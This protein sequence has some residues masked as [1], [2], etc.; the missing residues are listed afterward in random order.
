MNESSAPDPREE[1]I[2]VL[3]GGKVGGFPRTILLNSPVTGMMDRCGARWPSAHYDSDEMATLAAEIHLAT[4]FN[5]V[6]LPWDA[7]VELEALGGESLRPESYLDVPAPTGPAFD[8]PEK[9][10]IPDDIFE[11]GRF[12]VVFDAVR[13]VRE[14][15]GKHVAVVPL[16]EGPMNVACLTIGVNRMYRLFIRAPETARKV[17][18]RTARLCVEY[19]RRL[20][21]CGGDIIQISDPFAQGLTARHFRSLLIP[22]YRKIRREIDGPIF[23][24]ICGNTKGLLK[25]IPESGFQAFS[26]DSPAVSTR[27]V[28]AALGGKTR[29]VGSVPT[30]SC[31]LEGSEEDVFNASLECMR[32]GVDI[33]SPSCGLPPSTPLRNLLAM[34][35]AI[36]HCNETGPRLQ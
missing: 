20:F 17:L 28:V 4:G 22:V 1:V 3:E 23:L 10:D 35:E 25:Y 31:L 32:D 9:V 34:V 27:D 33:L 24:H 8:S 29:A 15:L 13:K 21:E 14:I 6:N 12:P 18:E 5:A 16:V 36:R 11:R 2:R 26:Y 30:V 7:C 19:G